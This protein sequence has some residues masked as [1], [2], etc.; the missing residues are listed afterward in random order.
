MEIQV[1]DIPHSGKDYT[2]EIAPGSIDLPKG[3]ATLESSVRA[4]VHCTRRETEV[5]VVGNS[6]ASFGTECSRCLD[7]TALHLQ[8]SLEGYFQPL[9]TE[10]ITRAEEAKEEDVGCYYYKNHHI[11]LLPMIAEI[12]ILDLPTYP[13]CD[14]NCQGICPECGRNKNQ[15]SCHCG[16]LHDH[17][18]NPFK[19]FFK[20]EG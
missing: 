11:D 4:E 3:V 18:D 14:V 8:V 9:S 16:D 5:Y 6:T 10:N 2:F 20:S 7:N 19:S 15:N 17:Q 13:L 1:N 12:L